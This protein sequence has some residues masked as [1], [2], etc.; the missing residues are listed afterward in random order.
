MVAGVFLGLADPKEP[1]LV[2]V[3]AIARGRRRPNFDIIIAAYRIG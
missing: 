3:A 2:A 1:Y